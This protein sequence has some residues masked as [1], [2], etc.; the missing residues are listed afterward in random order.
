MEILNKI[1]DALVEE[2]SVYPAIQV[3]DEL[4]E[5]YKE[6]IELAEQTSGPRLR[7]RPPRENEG[8][9]ASINLY[10]TVHDPRE[11]KIG[12]GRFK[13]IQTDSHQHSY[14]MVYDGGKLQFYLKP[15]TRV[16]ANQ[17]ERQIRKN[18]P[19]SQI[20]EADD[21]FPKFEKGD[22]VAMAGMRLKKPFFYPI[23]CKISEEEFE[24][25]PYGDITSDMV[26]EE[27]QTSDGIRV[28]AED[29]RVMV[30]TIFE[31]ARDVWTKKLP[32]GRNVTEAAAQIKEGELTGNHIQGWE[33]RDPGSKRKRSAK[34]VDK[35]HGAK[36]YYM[37]IRVVAISPYQEIAERR[38]N[39]VASDFEKYYNS[40]TEQGLEP[41]S[42]D[43]EDIPYHLK[44]VAGR[45]HDISWLSR[46]KFGPGAPTVLQPVSALGSIAH[47][48]N[49]EINTPVVDWAKQQTGPGVPAEAGRR[50]EEKREETRNG[51]RHP[52]VNQWATQASN[53][54]HHSRHRTS[55][56]SHPLRTQENGQSDPTANQNGQSPEQGAT[57]SG[58]D[59]V[60]EGDDA[61]ET[62][63]EQFNQ[64]NGADDSDPLVKGSEAQPGAPPDEPVES[65]YQEG[66]F[67]TEPEPA[68][69]QDDSDGTIDVF[70]ITRRGT[71]SESG[72]NEP[73]TSWGAADDGVDHV[74]QQKNSENSR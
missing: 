42:I 68:G 29:C 41:Y 22:Y 28:T 43:P 2:T 1:A 51:D 45:T 12:F 63:A 39:T 58:A 4:Y 16:D 13:F 14:E 32:Y 7:V 64:Q 70:G 21:M 37:T 60:G 61:L 10:E 36:G 27:D 17:F 19:N 40:F 25:D 3:D 52:G 20:A 50:D 69:S 6:G 30:Q 67:P 59:A 66:P 26:V 46:V 72:D 5:T 54:T 62:D 73:E 71:G 33:L 24:V 56:R 11:R 18:Y 47:I 15:D 44:Q 38:C 31:P 74:D 48:P 53:E 8:M 57:A 65:I 55:P 49:E 9:D 23:K 35:L 34:I